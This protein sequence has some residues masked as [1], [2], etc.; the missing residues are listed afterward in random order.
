M[1]LVTG[2][3]SDGQRMTD[4]SGDLIPENTVVEGRLSMVELR[5]FTW[6]DEQVKKLRWNF[7][8]TTPPWVG[9]ELSGETSLT[10]TP[11]PN[12]KA[13][14]WAAALMQRE[15][16]PG[17]EIDTDQMIGLPGQLLISHKTGKDG[18]VWLRIKEVFAAGKGAP[19]P[20]AASAEDELDAPF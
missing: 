2:Q 5:E 14:N 15:P 11:N 13:Y 20:A 6:N 7:T 10:F 17:E 8:A 3:G 1:K 4:D 18:R 9:R 19:V 12:C 16:A